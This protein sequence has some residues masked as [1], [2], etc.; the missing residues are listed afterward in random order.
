MLAMIRMR[1]YRSKHGLHF[2]II[3]QIHDAVMV[4]AP[5]D[6]IEATKTMFSS[7]MANIQIPMAIGEP[8]VLGIDIAVLDRWGQKRKKV[9]D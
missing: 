6:E 1:Q 4:E 2:R 9:E 3:N 7:T 5:I 8:L